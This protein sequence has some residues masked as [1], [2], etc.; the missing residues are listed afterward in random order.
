MKRNKEQQNQHPQTRAIPALVWSEIFTDGYFPDYLISWMSMPYE[1][2]SKQF[3]PVVDE[4]KDKAWLALAFSQ[5][6][7][8]SGKL[9]DIGTNLGLSISKMI[10]LA[11]VLGDSQKHLELLQMLY[12]KEPYSFENFKNYSLRLQ[13]AS[14]FGHLNLL[15]YQIELIESFS[16]SQT[17]DD[18]IATDNF[19]VFLEAARHNQLVIM[20]YLV[21]KRP[22]KVQEMIASDSYNV[23]AAAML[24]GHIDIVKYLTEKVADNLNEMIAS[25]NFFALRW[26]VRSNY[27]EIVQYLLSHPLAFAFT[28]SHARSQNCVKSFVTQKL[29]DLRE[30]QIES[31]DFIKS[32]NSGSFEAKLLFYIVRNLI[33]RNE[34]CLI[35]DLHFLLNI[36]AIKALAHSE[37][38]PDEPNELLRLA[39]SIDNRKAVTALLNIPLVRTNAEKN[40]YYGFEIPTLMNH[41]KIWFPKKGTHPLGGALNEIRLISQNNLYKARGEKLTLLTDFNSNQN[42]YIDYVTSFCN[43]HDI[44][45]VTPRDIEHELVNHDWADQSIQLKL[46]EIAMLELSHP[47]GHPVIASDIFRLLSPVLKLG[48]YSDIDIRLDYS[49]NKKTSSPIKCPELLINCDFE[50]GT[51][52]IELKSLCNNFIY[53]QNSEHDFLRVYRKNIASA[54]TNIDFISKLSMNKNVTIFEKKLIVDDVAIG[55]YSEFAK[56]YFSEN[57]SNEAN[58]FLSFRQQLKDALPQYYELFFYFY[59]MTCSGPYS[60]SDSFQNYA[61]SYPNSIVTLLENISLGHSNIPVHLI[62]ESVQNAS[63]LSWTEVG[64]NRLTDKNDKIEKSAY[65]IQRFWRKYKQ[66]SELVSHSQAKLGEPLFHQ[67]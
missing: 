16:G 42:K 27:C 28:E 17:M 66:E 24:N 36:P 34:A 46:F 65:A 45:L 19:G 22:E 3:T 57:P 49:Y 12:K 15:K 14:K 11:V 61:D 50:I 44:H 64:S 1:D 25:D 2:L 37:V 55:K 63:D 23:Y 58:N 29:S 8:E 21:E 53:A 4:E 7:F 33:R 62:D 13:R 43:K 56:K 39:L 40:R 41:L 67:L 30:K 26:A 54:Y 51:K 20:K 31:N 48:A 32:I 60:L 10:D 9:L 38:T 35:D 59:V 52:M 47:A 5:S 18:L 6:E